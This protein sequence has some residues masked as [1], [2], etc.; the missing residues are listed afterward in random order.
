VNRIVMATI[1]V[2]ILVAILDSTINK[3][4]IKLLQM[5]PLDSLT[6]KSYEKTSHI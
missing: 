3:K 2:A 5:S 1:L 6:L 4:G